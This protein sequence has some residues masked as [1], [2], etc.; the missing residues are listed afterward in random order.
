M[1]VISFCGES[2]TVDH[3]V[4]GA[5]Y[6]H[7]YDENSNLIVS[8]EGIQDFSGISYNGEYMTPGGCLAERC[9]DVKFCDGVFKTRDG[10]TVLIPF[11]AGPTILT[12]YQYGDELPTPGTPGRLFFKKV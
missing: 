12:S 11:S 6:I 2:F 1:P 4:K 3:A 5:D 7:G 8:L 9:N 10:V